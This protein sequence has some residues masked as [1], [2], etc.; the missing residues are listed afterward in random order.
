[1]YQP[2][3]RFS[4]RTNSK[5][6]SLQHVVFKRP[7]AFIR[8]PLFGMLGNF[9]FLRILCPSLVDDCSNLMDC[10]F[11]FVNVIDVGCVQALE[12]QNY[13]LDESSFLFT[14]GSESEF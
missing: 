2:S 9:H 1:M 12:V 8:S 14:F 7:F 4:L 3:I 6:L 11:E 10:L 13:F 5:V